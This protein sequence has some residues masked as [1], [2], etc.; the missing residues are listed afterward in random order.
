MSKIAGRIQPFEHG[1]ELVAAG[2]S[3]VIYGRLRAY[4]A[5]S[6]SSNKHNL[7]ICDAYNGTT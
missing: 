2:N 1:C 3:E 7:E 5:P 6:R 4:D